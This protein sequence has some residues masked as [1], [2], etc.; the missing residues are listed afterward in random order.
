MLITFALL[1]K[2][3]LHINLLANLQPEKYSVVWR[4]VDR[5]KQV[6]HVLWNIKYGKAK[7]ESEIAIVI[8]LW[9]H[10]LWFLWCNKVESLKTVKNV[11]VGQNYS[12]VFRCSTIYFPVWE[13]VKKMTLFLLAWEPLC[14]MTSFV[15][16]VHFE[17]LFGISYFLLTFL[18]WLWSR[19]R[20]NLEV[21]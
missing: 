2:I 13:I 12:K 5:E 15:F 18:Y 4:R 14:S 21:E 3:Y 10:R 20:L 1:H 19:K 17:L 16:S 11:Y 7:N 8:F 9:L 6:F